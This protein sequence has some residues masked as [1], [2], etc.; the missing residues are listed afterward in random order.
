VRGGK[1]WGGGGGGGGG[2]GWLM[3]LRIDTNGGF[4]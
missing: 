3:W 1:E 4:L 2:G